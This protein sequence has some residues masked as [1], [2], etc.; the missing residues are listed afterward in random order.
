MAQNQLST[1][2]IG[3]DKVEPFLF[4]LDNVKHDAFIGIEAIFLNDNFNV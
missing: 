3:P 4:K 2:F 1:T